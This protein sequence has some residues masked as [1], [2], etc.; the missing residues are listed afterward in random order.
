MFLSFVNFYWKFIWKYLVIVMPLMNLLKSSENSQKRDPFSLTL[1]AR[2]VFYKLQKAFS[3]E[4]VIH[5]YNLEC[6]IHLKMNT[7]E[8]AAGTIL[9]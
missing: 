2:K 5:H 8:H 6:R 4:P 7:S 9:L 3:R 1:T